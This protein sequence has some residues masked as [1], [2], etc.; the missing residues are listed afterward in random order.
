VFDQTAMFSPLNIGP[1]SFPETWVTNYQSTP[2]VIPEEQR[3]QLEEE[4]KKMVVDVV[5]KMCI[6]NNTLVSI[7]EGAYT[8]S[9]T[10]EYV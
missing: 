8:R 6:T 1:I 7:Y 2:C 5:G 3:P 9:L 10:Y 4:N